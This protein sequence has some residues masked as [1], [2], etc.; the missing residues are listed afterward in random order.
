[1]C[2]AYVPNPAVPAGRK[3]VHML[4][5]FAKEIWRIR[6]RRGTDTQVPF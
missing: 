1:M 4:T 3:P 2:K 5:E 6:R